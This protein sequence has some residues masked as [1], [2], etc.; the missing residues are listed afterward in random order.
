M[1]KYLSEV[2]D[3]SGDELVN[4]LRVSVSESSKI[5]VR[6]NTERIE[7]AQRESD[8]YTERVAQAEQ[9]EA[10]ATL[11]L[12]NAADARSKGEKSAAD[13]YTQAAKIHKES[14]REYHRKAKSLERLFR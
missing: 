12:V 2:V 8:A 6:H 3:L 1:A 5:L 9:K 13:D 10:E 14:A 11:A 7:Q 4:S